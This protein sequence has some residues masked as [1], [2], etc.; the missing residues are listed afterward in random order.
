MAKCK[1]CNGDFSK[2]F[3]F[4]GK[5]FDYRKRVNC[6]NCVP[7]RLSN[8]DKDLIEFIYGSEEKYKKIFDK[9]NQNVAKRKKIYKN[10]R[11]HVYTERLCPGCD[12]IFTKS[13]NGTFCPKCVSKIKT[14]GYRHFAVEHKGGKCELCGWKP[15]DMSEYICLDF[16]HANGVEKTFEFSKINGYSFETIVD[17]LPKCI[18]LC[19]ICH[20][21]EHKNFYN[22][23][24]ISAA[25]D[26][27]LYKNT[28]I[29]ELKTPGG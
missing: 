28:P 11:I 18:M 9:Y 3:K 29:N 6:Y 10:S 25:K 21:L 13:R 7:V 17:E 4:K 2:R 22:T 15:K 14:L 19:A 16:H 24:I 12:T 27:S 1:V 23:A 20:R 26:L 5:R 8:Y